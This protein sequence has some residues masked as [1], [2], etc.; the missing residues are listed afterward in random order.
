MD[1]TYGTTEH[2]TA[3]TEGRH[4]GVR[5]G[6]QWLTFSHLPPLLQKYSRPFYAAACELI[7][8][9]ATDSPE[10]TTAINGLIAAKDSAVRAGIRHDT[11]RAG[12]VPRPQQVVDPPQLGDADRMRTYADTPAGQQLAREDGLLD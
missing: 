1:L 11:G 5:D 8:D 7:G 4:P 6:L 12:S 2:A 9:V 10:L 3:V